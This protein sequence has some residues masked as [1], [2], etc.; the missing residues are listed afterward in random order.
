MTDSCKVGYSVD[1]LDDLRETYAYIVNELLIPKTAANQ[2]G[3]LVF[4]ENESASGDN[5]IVNYLV[6]DEERAVTAARIFYGGR[7]IE[8]IINSNK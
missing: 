7:D 6:N 5:F 1:A 4:G 3:V 2:L 8:G